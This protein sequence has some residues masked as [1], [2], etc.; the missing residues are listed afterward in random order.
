MPPR[1]TEHCTVNDRCRDLQGGRK[2]ADWDALGEGDEGGGSGTE[3]AELQAAIQLSLAESPLKGASC[4]HATCQR[5]VRPQHGIDC[6]VSS[7]SGHSCSRSQQHSA[8]GSRSA[9]GSVT[10]PWRLATGAVPAAAPPAQ[11]RNR[12]D[13][14]F[15]QRL[16]LYSHAGA[17]PADSEDEDAAVVLSE[18]P[19][20]SAP[21]QSPDRRQRAAPAANAGPR[22]TSA[23]AQT[24]G[25]QRSSADAVGH[26]PASSGPAQTAS[27]QRRA[28]HVTGG[29]PADSVPAAQPMQ[30]ADSDEDADTWQFMTL[31]APSKG[32]PRSSVRKDAAPMGPS[33]QVPAAQ[34]LSLHGTAPAA[35]PAAPVT[36]GTGHQVRLVLGKSIIVRE[37][38]VYGELKFGYLL[39]SS[40]ASML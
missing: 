3:D 17:S 32:P 1:V 26:D 15:S 38:R 13:S 24:A 19:A 27:Q 31:P 30:R 40:D 16:S 14:G 20:P 29:T 4:S 22:S 8:Q 6:A 37:T 12:R 9:P 2:L 10:L 33:R 11:A 23:P 36:G 39:K 21:A 18:R 7:S 34:Q 25:Q 5:H 28:V 35:A